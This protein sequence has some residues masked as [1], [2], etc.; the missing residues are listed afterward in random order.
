MARRVHLG[1]RS[2]VIRLPCAPLMPPA[3]VRCQVTCGQGHTARA[4]YSGAVLHGSK[5]LAHYREYWANGTCQDS[6]GLRGAPSIYRVLRS[7]TKRHFRWRP[8]CC[9]RSAASADV[10]ESTSFNYE[11]PGGLLLWCHL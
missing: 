7:G 4:K 8:R 9:K 11:C 5:H 1:A 3:G 6:R 10:V 2:L